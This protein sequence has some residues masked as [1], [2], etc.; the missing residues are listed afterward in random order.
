M[1]EPFHNWAQKLCAIFE[2]FWLS[3]GQILDLYC[4]VVPKNTG[5]EYDKSLVRPDLNKVE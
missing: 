2:Y 3:G 4:T 1:V 5:R